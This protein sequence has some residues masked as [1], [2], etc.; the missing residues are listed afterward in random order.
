LER[1]HKKDVITVTRPSGAK[2]KTRLY[3][4]HFFV[5]Q[6]ANGTLPRFVEIDR[7]TEQVQTTKAKNDELRSW[8]SKVDKYLAYY[9]QGFY[10]KRYH[11]KSVGILTCTTSEKRLENLMQVTQQRGGRTEFWFTT[12]PRRAEPTTDFL[13]SPIWNRATAEGLFSA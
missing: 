4:D 11:T 6:V 2:L 5:L 10:E 12:Y 3:P 1:A 9:Y 7:S 8:A 13:T